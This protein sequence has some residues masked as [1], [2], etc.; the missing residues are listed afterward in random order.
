MRVRE[1][2][3][4]NAVLPNPQGL[5][6]PLPSHRQQ[7]RAVVFSL[8]RTLSQRLQANLKILEMARKWKRK[9]AESNVVTT[10]AD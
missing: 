7:A 1:R 2:A 5:L 4:T 3:R 10:T 6:V 9:R 8:T